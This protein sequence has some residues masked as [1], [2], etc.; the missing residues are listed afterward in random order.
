MDFEILDPLQEIET[1]AV[2]SGIREIRRL[3]RIYGTGRWRKRRGVC[4]VRLRT[5][6]IRLAEIHWYEAHGLGRYEY[7]IKRYLD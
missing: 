6:R 7:K 3:R 5:G 4:R 1:I 2:G